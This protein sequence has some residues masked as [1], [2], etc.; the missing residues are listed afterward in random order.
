MNFAA[1]EII[2]AQMNLADL[3]LK[4][5]TKPIVFGGMAME[6]Y[7]LRE[8]GHDIDLFVSLEDYEALA[9]KYPD[10]R[11]D[12]WG[13][14]GVEVNGFE[15]W[16]SIW[17]LD[18]QYFLA[19]AVEYDRYYVLSIEKLLLTKALAAGVSEKHRVDLALIANHIWRQNANP[20]ILAYMNGHVESYLKVADGFV[21]KG[22]Y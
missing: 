5:M 4:L 17:K 12:S 7:W 14:L 3:G 8:R 21:Y 13:D 19:G 16:R 15:V 6:H 18:Y 9:A 22:E 2:D 10:G 20:E 11:K 1:S